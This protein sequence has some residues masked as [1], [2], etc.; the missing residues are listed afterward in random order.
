MERERLVSGLSEH[1]QA[2]Y[3]AKGGQS[4]IY[5]LVVLAV[6][7]YETAGGAPRVRL[8]AR[9]LAV[10]GPPKAFFT[11]RLADLVRAETSEVFA[12]GNAYAAD[13]IAR[14]GGTEP[15]VWPV[16]YVR[17]T[18]GLPEFV[19]DPA[20]APRKR[21]RYAAGWAFLVPE[22]LEA[23]LDIAMTP[24]QV[25]EKGPDGEMVTRST[26]V[27]TRGRPPRLAFS[28]GDLI[29]TTTDARPDWQ[30]QVITARPADPEARDPGAVRV[31]VRGEKAG[32]LAGVHDLTQGELEAVLREGMEGFPKRRRVADRVGIGDYGRLDRAEE[33]G[34]NL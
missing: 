24:R 14:H 13:L 12:D 4:G 7:Y 9:D 19:R 10:P 22:A 30:I 34:D 18:E 25:R 17:V 33:D 26:G 15:P 16:V 28:V 8:L 1:V 20:R 31:L 6:D 29:P 3:F 11:N 27:R 21:S 2:T 23:A 5:G 32:E